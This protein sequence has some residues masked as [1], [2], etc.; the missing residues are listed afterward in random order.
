MGKAVLTIFLAGIGGLLLREFLRWIERSAD[1]AIRARR[2]T[3][4]DKSQHVASSKLDTAD[5]P[6]CPSCKG[7]MVKR[8]ARRG[9]HAGSEFWGCSLFPKCRGTRPI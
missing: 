1:R 2:Q 8:K 6:P 7:T 3:Q 9:S 5:G 4:E